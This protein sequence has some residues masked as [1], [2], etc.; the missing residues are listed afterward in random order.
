VQVFLIKSINIV[1]L[2]CVFSLNENLH[3][4]LAPKRFP[5]N[6]LHKKMARL[7]NKS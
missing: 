2:T 6:V 3:N 5:S 7:L 4:F 1:L